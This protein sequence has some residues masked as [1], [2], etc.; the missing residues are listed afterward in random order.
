MTTIVVVATIGTAFGADWLHFR[1]PNHNGV[2]DG[3]QIPV[4]WSESENVAWKAELPGRGASGPIVVG[5]RVFLT[6]SFGARDD[7][8]ST[9]CF[10]AKTGKKWWDRQIRATGRVSCHPKMCMATPTPASDGKHVV[11]FYSCNDVACFDLEGNLLW[12]RGL[13]Y[14]YPN[15]SCTVGMSS[16]PVIVDGVA[17]LQIENQADS[18]SCG[19]DVT[20]G[21]T[22][23]K[24]ERPTETSWASPIVIDSQ[25]HGPL[26]LLQSVGKLSAHTPRTGRTVWEY[27]AS[28]NPIPSVGV[29]KDLRLVPVSRDGL[30][31]LR[32]EVKSESPEVVF[33]LPAASPS[34]PSP[35]VVGGRAYTITGPGILNC[36][37]LLAGKS[38]WKER[39]K[40]PFSSTPVAAG[41]L[42][43]AFNED[44]QGHVI[45]LLSD[46]AEILSVNHLKE[47][48]LC[49]PAIAGDAVY[50]RSDKH[51]WKIQAK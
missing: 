45:R 14:D 43:V 19:L 1:G 26:V 13:N 22:L 15:A 46:K 21:E 44:G 17:V 20:T 34:T 4:K 25:K 41:N 36:I 27:K 37:D 9:L 24:I 23:W 11:S 5:D 30:V 31:A 40:G 51:L 10:D 16:S 39:L 38:L 3:A 7:R 6:A 48:I 2:A 8:L 33:K 50:V 29:S 12:C 32:K 49:S 18:F 35:I 42:L 28:C 47:T